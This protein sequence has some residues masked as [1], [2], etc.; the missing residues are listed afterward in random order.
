MRSYVTSPN[1]MHETIDG[2]TIVIDL[3]IGTYFSLRGSGPVIWNALAS[4]SSSE[5]I[6]ETL[7]AAYEASHEEIAGAAAAFL[8]RLEEERLIVKGN[9][10][11]PA[12]DAGPN[13]A[14]PRAPF[15]PPQLERYDDL[16][17][18]ILLDPVHMVDEQGWPHA[19][20]NDS[21]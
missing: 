17:D 15:E 1:A 5:A 18:I 2:E 10:A 9:G 4:G 21:A 16:Q 14:G 6:V 13:H 12:G 19:A 3:S 7:A 20:G 8:A 11:G